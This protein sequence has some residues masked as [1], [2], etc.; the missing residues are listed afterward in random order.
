MNRF[1]KFLIGLLLLP[2]V[3]CFIFN[4]M[5]VVFDVVKNFDI[6]F[7]FLAGFVLYCF[8]H[9][10]LYNFSRPYVFAH[11]VS[12]ALA[13]WCCGYKVTDIKV[14]ED[15]GATKVSNF[16]TFVLLA[17]YCLPLY[18]IIIIAGFY[19]TSLFW[20]DIFAYNKIF[21]GLIGFFMALHLVHTYKSLTETEQSDISLAGGWLFSFTLIAVINLSLSVLLIHFLF[22]SV[23]SPIALLK[24]VFLQTVDFWKY[25]FMYVHKGIVKIGNL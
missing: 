6:T 18:V 13:A 12:H 11:E 14:N 10:Y 19:I 9:K 16:N 25:F 7:T 20:K 15:S 5:T 2:T 21:L 3:F 24:V 23:I 22:P 17:P 4:F 1:L 8:V